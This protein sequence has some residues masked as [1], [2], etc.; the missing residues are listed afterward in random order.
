MRT[1]ARFPR[2]STASFNALMMGEYGRLA[3]RNASTDAI[4]AVS[5]C[6]SCDVALSSTSA[7]SGWPMAL[8]TLIGPSPAA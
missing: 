1:T 2:L 6:I 3:C 4:L 5:D 7:L 8:K